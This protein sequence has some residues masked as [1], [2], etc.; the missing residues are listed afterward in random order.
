MGGTRVP[1][2]GHGLGTGTILRDHL[3]KT[4]SPVDGRVYVERAAAT[5]D[6][7]D[8]TLQRSRAAQQQWRHVPMPERIELMQRFCTAFEARAADIGNELSWQMGRPIRYAPNEVRGTLER[9]RY[10]IG[11]ASAAL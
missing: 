4:I 10:M 8:A 7:I 3:M 2:R 5:P 11:A 9:A 6:E 1:A